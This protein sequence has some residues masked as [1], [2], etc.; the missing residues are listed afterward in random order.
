[1]RQLK[2]GATFFGSPGY[3]GEKKIKTKIMITQH[4][5]TANFQKINISFLL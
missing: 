1:M 2:K 4:L 5:N 3:L